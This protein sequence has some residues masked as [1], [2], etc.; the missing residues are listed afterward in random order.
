[1]IGQYDLPHGPEPLLRFGPAEGPQLL[2]LLPLFEEHNRTRAFAVTLLRALAALGIGA[3]LPEMP[4]QGESLMPTEALRLATLQ[5]AVATLAAAMPGRGHAVSI[6]S[7]ALLVPEGIGV[8][9]WSLS[10]QPGSALCRELTR[11]AGAPIDRDAPVVEIAGN[12]IAGAL[13]GELEAAPAPAPGRTVR[14]A[15]DPAAADL[16]IDAP[17]PWRGAEPGN[18][19]ALA[20][21][22]ATDIAAW[23]GRCAG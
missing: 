4:G 11:I 3:L 23:V 2:M 9:H 21:R 1:M 17:P 5:R 14:L 22:L 19:P 18:D 20:A 8:P 10:P 15:S 7:G 13:I 6:R 12:R 16:K